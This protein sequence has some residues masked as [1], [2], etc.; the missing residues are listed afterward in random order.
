MKKIILFTILSSFFYFQSFAWS[1]LSRTTSG[2][3]FGYFGSTSRQLA[4]GG[5][6]GWGWVITCSGLGTNSCPTSR[7]VP[8]NS[9]PALE[10]NDY[11]AVIG[12]LA[13]VDPI[14]DASQPGSSGSRSLTISVA[15]EQF[16]RHYNLTWSKNAQGATV[17]NIDRTDY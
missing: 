6:E 4:E 16:N 17:T 10:T 3:L 5:P 7:A 12:L 14:I 13:I 8:P 1:V 2:G 9:N 15:G 11:N